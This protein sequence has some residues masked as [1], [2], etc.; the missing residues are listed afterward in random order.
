VEYGG[1]QEF[2][3]VVSDPGCYPDHWEVRFDRLFLYYENLPA[4]TCDISIQAL[5]SYSGNAI[6]MPMRIYEMYK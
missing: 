6:T 1:A 5:Q 2:P 3:F 4:L